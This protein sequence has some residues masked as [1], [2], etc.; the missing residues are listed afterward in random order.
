MNDEKWLLTMQIYDEYEKRFA[1]ARVNKPFYVP[2]TEEDRR[3]IVD[4]VKHMLAY[5]DALLPTIGDMEEIRRDVCDGF[6]IIQLHYTTWENFHS[7]ATLFLPHGEEKVPLTF[8]F[9][10]HGA[11][12]RLTQGHPL[13]AERLARRGMAV[14]I[15]D[16]IGQ[17]DRAA[18]GHNYVVAP[19]YCGLTLQGMILMESVALIRHMI[20]HPR[21]D[22]A[23]V[24]AC[25]NSGGG[26]LCLFL[27]ALA[28]E[29]SA[30]CSTGYPSEFSYILS[31][32]RRH[33][34]CNLLPGCAHG[35]EMWE[36]LSAFA[37]KPLLI[38]QGKNDDLIPYDLF[39]RNARKVEHV[40]RQMGVAERFKAMRAEALHPWISA[41]RDIIEQFLCEN[42]GVGG[43]SRGDDETLP[44]R[45][46]DWH[47]ALPE[48]SITTEQLAQKLSSKTMPEGTKLQDIFTPIYQSKPI[49]EHDIVSDIGRGEVM[50]VLAQME[51]ALKKRE[52]Q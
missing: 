49:D 10:G 33:C 20:K 37:P 29:L 43:E 3:K 50:R 23:R 47:V 4:S 39:M 30:L 24:A 34:A 7:A 22:A 9:C 35:P 21:V 41:D 44:E 12:G 16:N 46:A 38:E 51:C 2:T 13:M 14:M 52:D 19:F 32:E 8:V 26:T 1:E 6:D 28:P 36:V 40:Y 11:E 48:D 31:K 45:L 25:G 17:G 15:P 42:L 18:Y 5:D 27:A